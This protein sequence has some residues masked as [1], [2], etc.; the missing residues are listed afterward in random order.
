MKVLISILI[1]VLGI[2][3]GVSSLC[4]GTAYLCGGLPEQVANSEQPGF[5]SWFGMGVLNF[6]VFLG[7][8]LAPAGM[9]A[10]LVL[11]IL[12]FVFKSWMRAFA[13]AGLTAVSFVLWHYLMGCVV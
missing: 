13:S 9:L 12:S 11:S 2:A 5:W 4:A 10:G 6:S 8:V 1:F 3:V 7:L